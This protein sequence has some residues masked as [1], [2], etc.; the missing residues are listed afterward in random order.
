MAVANHFCVGQH[1]SQS[2]CGKCFE[3]PPALNV[4]NFMLSAFLFLLEFLYISLFSLLSS[5]FF[6]S[7][8]INYIPI[9]LPYNAVGPTD[10]IA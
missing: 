8:S 4:N 9:I 2:L 1:T 6:P 5:I 10:D 3:F 7:K